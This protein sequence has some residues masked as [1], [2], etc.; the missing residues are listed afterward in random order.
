MQRAMDAA[1]VRD[2]ARVSRAKVVA[3]RDV[4]NVQKATSD[5]AKT[6]DSIVGIFSRKQK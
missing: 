2:A 6:A 5:L 4:V 1:R 3:A